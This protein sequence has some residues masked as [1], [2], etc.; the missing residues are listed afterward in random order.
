MCGTT[1]SPPLPLA[2]RGSSGRSSRGGV[3]AE[4]LGGLTMDDIRMDQAGSSSTSSAPLEPWERHFSQSTANHSKPGRLQLV[5]VLYFRI[6]GSCQV[7]H[8]GGVHGSR[9]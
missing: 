7:I 2:P 3:P 9:N 5:S 6:I 8:K 4:V 1:I